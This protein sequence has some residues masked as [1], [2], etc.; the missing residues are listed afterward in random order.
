MIR[1]LKPLFTAAV[2]T[3]VAMGFAYAVPNAIQ[4]ESMSDDGTEE[5]VVVDCPVDEGSSDDGTEGD[6]TEGD[7][8]EDDGTEDDATEDCDEEVAEEDGE[9]EPE[10]EALEGGT[11][12]EGENHG[13]VVRV[14]A[15]CP[16]KGSAHG[17]LVSSIARDKDAT[18]A[19]AEAACE[20]ALAAAE[21]SGERVKG[22]KPDKAPKDK[23]GKPDHAGKGNPH[24]D[25][26]SDG[27]SGEGSEDSGE[28]QGGSGN[29][30]GKHK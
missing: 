4:L 27:D 23:G 3:V 13:Q 30:N 24:A 5:T 18:V 15:H 9:E 20:E 6:G 21:G 19:D 28:A 25:D 8:T 17:V 2:F 29:G 7:G 26:G 11:D 14:A 12:G 10:A 1:Q 16:I 22:A